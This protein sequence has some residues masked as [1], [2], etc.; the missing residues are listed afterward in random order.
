MTASAPGTTQASRELTIA[1]GAAAR[2]AVTPAAR[3]VRARGEVT[4]TAAATDA[5]GNA[6]S[7]SVTWS[8]TPASL[9]TLVRAAGRAR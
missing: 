3:E 7:A 1:A 6:A 9:G 5:F 2:V 4:F 8:V